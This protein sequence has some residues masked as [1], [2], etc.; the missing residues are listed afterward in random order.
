VLKVG[1]IKRKEFAWNSLIRP[2]VG[3]VY[4]EHPMVIS[5]TDMIGR[6]SRLSN[7]PAVAK[8]STESTDRGADVGQ[9][10]LHLV[11]L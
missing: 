10:N 2:A 7:G 8:V 11:S 5:E 1:G 6:M 9:N 3:T 4:S